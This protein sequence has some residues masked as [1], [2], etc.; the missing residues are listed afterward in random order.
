MAPTKPLGL[1]HLENPKTKPGVTGFEQDYNQ[2]SR[3]FPDLNPD[4]VT[5]PDS[6]PKPRTEA[7]KAPVAKPARARKAPKAKK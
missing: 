2:E 6:L 4:V 7:V 1:S 3:P 5:D